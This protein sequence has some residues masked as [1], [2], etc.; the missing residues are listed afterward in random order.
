MALASAVYDVSAEFPVDERFGMTRQI[1]RAAIS[2]AANIAE[3]G[4]RETDREFRR[5]VTIS[6]GSLEE[7]RTYV[8]F[9]DLR[10]WT[11]HDLLRAVDSQC[12]QLG[13]EIMSLLKK[14]A[15]S[16]Q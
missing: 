7:V 3:G 4:G 9:A 15:A 16:S 5:F 14:P 2:V 12:E 13:R 11:K 1:R 10:G 6:L 8:A